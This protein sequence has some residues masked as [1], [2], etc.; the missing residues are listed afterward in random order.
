MMPADFSMLH[1]EDEMSAKCRTQREMLELV[2]T[3]IPNINVAFGEI[4]FECLTS[5]S[6]TLIRRERIW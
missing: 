3:C 2:Q 1:L 5:S 6:A 4:S